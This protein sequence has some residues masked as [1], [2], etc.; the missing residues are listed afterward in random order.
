MIEFNLF[1]ILVGAF[2]IFLAWLDI[3][4]K[5]IYSFITT[6]F[7]LIICMMQPENIIYYGFLSS[8]FAVMLWEMDYIYRLADIKVITIIGL[9]INSFAQFIWMMILI[10]IIGLC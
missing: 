6:A 8:I 1:S 2:L 3:K 9:M 5:E 10:G 4:S 7:I